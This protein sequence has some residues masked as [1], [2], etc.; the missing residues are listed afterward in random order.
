[1]GHS[2][3]QHL[4]SEPTHLPSP[5]GCLTVCDADYFRTIEGYCTR[6]D[7]SSSGDYSVLVL[8]VLAPLIVCALVATRFFRNLCRQLAAAEARDS[9]VEIATS[10]AGPAADKTAEG[11]RP[12]GRDSARR[13]SFASVLSMGV[14]LE[15]TAEEDSVAKRA[16]R[17]TDSLMVKFKIV[18]SLMQVIKQ[19]PGVYDM[20]MPSGWLTFTR[21]LGAIDLDFTRYLR[22]L[23]CSVTFDYHSQLLLRTL[24]AIAGIGL[25]AAIAATTRLVKPRNVSRFALRWIS[26]KFSY[27]SLL[28]TF[29]VYPSVS[30]ATFNT[31]LCDNF[32]DGS[33]A[34]VADLSVD[35]LSSKHR[36]YESY[37]YAMIVLFPIG[38]PLVFALLLM[39]TKEQRTRLARQDDGDL[40]GLEHLQMLIDPYSPQYYYFEILECG[41]KML[42][43]GITVFLERGSVTQMTLAQAVAVLS[44]LMYAATQPYTSPL[45]NILQI[46]CQFDVFIVLLFGQALRLQPFL[47]ADSR[48]RMDIAL[49]ILTVIPFVL[50]IPALLGEAYGL[51]GELGLGQSPTLRRATSSIS[52]EGA[53]AWK[54]A[55]SRLRPVSVA[56]QPEVVKAA[57]WSATDGDQGAGVGA[58]EVGASGA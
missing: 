50:C 24:G 17:A 40:E 58:V 31:F 13:A 9:A 39:R 51:C 35:C 5:H 48:R 34:L 45:D 20:Q 26:D 1:M 44:L 38:V 22:A 3:P 52:A 37:A 7:S 16:V 25:L 10:T 19:L 32:S 36:S 2:A 14:G 11:S 57:K 55:T 12:S 6:C 21:L 18:V 15:D 56:K 53:R 23:T 42:L 47:D 4:E 33:S 8:G 49:V 27:A 30:T 28:L 54:R 41:R 43:I 46:I 29:L